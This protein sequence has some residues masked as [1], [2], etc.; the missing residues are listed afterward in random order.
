LRRRPRRS[1][2]R[3]VAGFILAGTFPFLASVATGL[4]PGRPSPIPDWEFHPVL[5]A[6]PG[7]SSDPQP[8][9]TADLRPINDFQLTTPPPDRPQ[10]SLQA[11]TVIVVPVQTQPEPQ[12]PSVSGFVAMGRS[13]S[14]AASWYCRAGWS[15]CTTTHPDG[16]G[17][18]AYAAAGPALRAA[19]G[20]TWRG[21]IVTVNGIRVKLIDWCQCFRGES[22]EKLLD[23]YYDVFARTGSSV[24][25]RW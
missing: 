4:E 17:F 18:D 23:L 25:I 14:G 8:V 6:R 16:Q 12:P 24:T 22:S 11:P 19:I 3:V 2:L 20:P 9:A 21:R 7:A 13:I 1:W 5:L 15:P 10:P